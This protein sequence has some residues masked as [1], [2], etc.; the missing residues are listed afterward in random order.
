MTERQADDR[1]GTNDRD[2]ADDENEATG[3]CETGENEPE[4][5][6]VAATMAELDALVDLWLALA[7]DQRE[8]GSH[9][10]VEPNAQVVRDRLAE[11][12]VS[13]EVFLARVRP[14]KDA[15]PGEAS[16]GDDPVGFVLVS[17]ERG[18]YE[19]DADRGFVDALF[20]QPGARGRGIGSSLLDRGERRLAAAGVDV[21]GIEAMA[22]NV[23][24]RR[25]YRRR[26]Y[27]LH[28]VELE[29]KLP[30]R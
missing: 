23:D 19:R 1:N 3:E 17:R 15:P 29:K 8:A 12:I 20:V 11:G 21:V 2:E 4:H 14:T 7:S 9:L 5:T 26:G 18:S 13:E 25:L 24:A 30:D 27:E 28:R 16:S 10:R 6:V 22:S